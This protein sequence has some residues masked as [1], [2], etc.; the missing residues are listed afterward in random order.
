MA[1]NLTGISAFVNKDKV[2]PD[3]DPERLERDEIGKNAI[4]MHESRHSNTLSTEAEFNAVLRDINNK[5]GLKLPPSRSRSHSRGKYSESYSSY[6]DDY[7]DYSYSYSDSRSRNRS[8]SRSRSRDRDPV[9]KIFGLRDKRE[10]SVSRSKSRSHSH[11]RS[12]SRSKH[13]SYK[14]PGD[15]LL[16]E[17]MR[18][19]SGKYSHPHS[20]PGS[21][22]KSIDIEQYDALYDATLELLAE[23]KNRADVSQIPE[24]QRGRTTYD[25]LKL[26]NQMLNKKYMKLRCETLGSDL[27][28]SASHLLE[29]NF[30]GTKKIGPLK[31]NLTNFTN[32]MRPRVRRLKYEISETVAEMLEA[33]GVGRKSQ[34]LLEL[35][36]AVLIHS[37]DQ[38]QHDDVDNIGKSNMRN[39]SRDLDDLVDA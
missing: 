31:L 15:D 14:P 39:V 12:R 11:R 27:I 20:T 2:K 23:V 1:T 34:L 37:G 5:S 17:A 35:G 22:P 26:I 6:T 29:K 13:H 18:N 38:E 8:R 28:L 24:I 4:N 7:S 33:L 30:D 21:T 19:F 16:D 36:T 3:I 25:E 32:N 9:D 10:H